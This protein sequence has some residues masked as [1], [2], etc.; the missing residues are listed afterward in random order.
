MKI[1]HWKDIL[2]L[3]MTMMISHFR[4]TSNIDPS[5]IHSEGSKVFSIYF[6]QLFNTSSWIL[7]RFMSIGVLGAFFRGGPTISFCQ[8]SILFCQKNILSGGPKFSNSVLPSWCII[9]LCHTALPVLTLG[10]N[11][12]MMTQ[13]QAKWKKNRQIYGR[14]QTKMAENIQTWQKTW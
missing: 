3:I 11:C 5:I 14:N 6:I 8:N 2:M 13:K 9:L 7:N 1:K 12:W 10:K 4:M